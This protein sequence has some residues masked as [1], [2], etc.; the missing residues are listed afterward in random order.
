MLKT[1]HRKREEL[2]LTKERCRTHEIR[3][4]EADSVL[5]DG[6]F[7]A[8]NVMM[9]MFNMDDHKQVLKTI[10]DRLRVG[11]TLVLTEPKVTL[12]VKPIIAGAEEQLRVSGRL[13]HL[14]RDWKIV[15]DSGRQLAA[16]LGNRVRVEA[17]NGVESIKVWLANNGFEIR[18]EVNTRYFDQC[19]TIVAEKKA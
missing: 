14:E 4:E 16:K 12:D 19:I 6:Q 1:L 15:A 3:A 11:G 13:A 2:G 10:H 7:D 5:L 8:V 18:K 17:W 9:C